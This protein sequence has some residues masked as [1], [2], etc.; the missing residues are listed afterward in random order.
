[1]TKQEGL[2]CFFLRSGLSAVF[3][4]AAIASFLEPDSWI[5]Y[6]PSFL[7]EII[8]PSP[9]LAAFSIYEIL[10][11]LWLLS[12]WKPFAAAILASI[13]LS[14]IILQ[15]VR[16]FEVVFRDV[17]VLSGALALAVMSFKRR[18]DRRHG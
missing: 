11:A 15:N 4:Y 5:G 3:L 6:L 9:L 8:S 7:R 2:A 12:G 17:A 18:E 1:M 14:A 16:L 10:L 13:T